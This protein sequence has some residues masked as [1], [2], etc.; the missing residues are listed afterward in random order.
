MLR[1]KVE[2]S[3]VRAAGSAAWEPKLHLQH[4][5]SHLLLKSETS[6]QQQKY[7]GDLLCNVITA[8]SI[9]RGCSCSQHRLQDQGFQ[10]QF[11]LKSRIGYTTNTTPSWLEQNLPSPQQVLGLAPEEFWVAAGWSAHER[12]LPHP[13]ALWYPNHIPFLCSYKY[14]CWR[15]LPLTGDICPCIF[16]LHPFYLRIFHLLGFVFLCS[17]WVLSKASQ[18]ILGCSLPHQPRLPGSQTQPLRGLP[19]DCVSLD[20]FSN[21]SQMSMCY[22]YINLGEGRRTR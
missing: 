16:K 5:S 12:F 8:N 4:C 21:I 6:T 17:L 22:F 18:T 9:N 13:S 11:S 20:A 2:D 10:P 1:L 3:E 14:R 15:K 19:G 7:P